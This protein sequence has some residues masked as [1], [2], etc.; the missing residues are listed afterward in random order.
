MVSYDD[1]EEDQSDL[2][3]DF[4]AFDEPDG[5]STSTRSSAETQNLVGSKGYAQPSDTEGMEVDI[6]NQGVATY[7]V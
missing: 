4:S 3:L 2:K 1:Y 7:D 5:D 6:D